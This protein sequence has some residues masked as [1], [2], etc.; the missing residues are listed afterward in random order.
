MIFDGDPIS[1]VIGKRQRFK[2]YV[3]GRTAIDGVNVVGGQG[4]QDT[5]SQPFVMMFNFHI[6][7]C[8][9]KIGF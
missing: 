7:E 8:K 3:W 2:C 9:L 6:F 5:I 4:V 1:I